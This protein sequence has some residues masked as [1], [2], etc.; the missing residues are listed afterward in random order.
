MVLNMLKRPAMST[1]SYG[2]RSG[3]LATILDAPLIYYQ[4]E[5][6]ALFSSIQLESS[7]IQAYAGWPKKGIW[8]LS[9]REVWRARKNLGDE[10]GFPWVTM[11]Y[12]VEVGGYDHD[13]CCSSRSDWESSHQEMMDFL[14]GLSAPTQYTRPMIIVVWLWMSGHHEKIRQ[15]RPLWEFKKTTSADRTCL[16]LSTDSRRR[17]NTVIQENK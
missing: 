8:S 13:W 2:G 3:M 9:I 10:W 5:K 12:L 17:K 7:L 6:S 11:S 14:P 15:W 1:M 16:T 4:K